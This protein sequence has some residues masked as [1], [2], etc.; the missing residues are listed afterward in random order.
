MGGQPPVILVVD[1]ELPHRKLAEKLLKAD[2]YC[3]R[4]AAS[5]EAAL[6]EVAR[7]PP[8]L[9][10]VDIMM[11]GMDGVELVKRLKADARTRPIPVIM[12]TSLDNRGARLRALE[13]GAEEF[14]SKPVDR[15]EL[16]V[17]IRNLLRL[18]EYG[19]FLANYNTILERQ[20]GERTRDLWSSYRETVLVLTRAAEYRDEDTGQHV[21]RVSEYVT[22]LARAMNLDAEF[23]DCIFH[24]SPMHDVGKLGIPDN[25]LLKPSP[26]SAAEWAVMKCH[27]VLGAK[28]LGCGNS[29]YLRM[30]RSIALTHHERWDGSG[31]PDGLKGEEI[32]LA[33]RIMA[34]SDVYDALRSKRPYKPALPHH[35]A[36]GIITQGDGRTLPDHFDPAVLNAF[37][38]SAGRF[39][40][41]YNE[42]QDRTA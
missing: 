18:K 33:G 26:L 31:Y 8:D 35:H 36:V 6:A 3:T 15:S 21:V 16:R 30:A 13:A 32:P 22:E 4:T 14:L 7:F 20:V 19:D 2:H 39:E 5:G 12:V 34:V 40:T 41:I 1:D 24:A 25:I 27:C 9:I 10:L 23:Q 28:I 37:R 11:P 17:R 42:F 38:R 29:P